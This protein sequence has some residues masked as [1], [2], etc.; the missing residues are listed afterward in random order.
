MNIDLREKTLSGYDEHLK[1]ELK[2]HW[3]DG[4]EGGFGQYNVL[5]HLSTYFNNDV[6]VDIGTGHQAISARALSYNKTNMVY[7]Y[8]TEFNNIAKDHI[9]GLENVEYNVFNPIKDHKDRELMLSSSLISL[10]VDPHD[11]NQERE[12][13]CF[14]VDNDWKGIIVCDDIK[15]GPHDGMKW[16]WESVDKPKY[17]ITD[18]IYSHHTGTGIICFDNQEIML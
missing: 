7:S 6:I 16:F 3:N 14:F 12:F 15:I 13:Y 9:D 4:P 10:D 5:S 11:G 8:D 18:T 1:E 2:K 17:D